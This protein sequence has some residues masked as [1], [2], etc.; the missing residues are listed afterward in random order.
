MFTGPQIRKMLRLFGIRLVT[1]SPGGYECKATGTSKRTLLL[2]S[3]KGAVRVSGYAVVQHD[4]GTPSPFILSPVLEQPIKRLT[5]WLDQPVTEVGFSPEVNSIRVHDG[6]YMRLLEQIIDNLINNC[7]NPTK[8]IDEILGL[9]LK[10]NPVLPTELQ[11]LNIVDPGWRLTKKGRY[12]R[13]DI[14]TSKLTYQLVAKRKAI[15]IRGKALLVMDEFPTPFWR[16]LVR[17]YFVKLCGQTMHDYVERVTNPY[18]VPLDAVD[19]QIRNAYDRARGARKRKD[20]ALNYGETTLAS[21]PPCIHRALDE[22]LLDMLRFNL[23]V[24]VNHITKERNLPSGLI[25]GQIMT[26]VSRSPINAGRAH[27]IR[28]RVESELKKAGGNYEDPI[29]CGKRARGSRFGGIMCVYDSPE[30][31]LHQRKGGDSLRPDTATIPLVWLFTDPAKR[32]ALDEEATFGDPDQSDSS[33]PGSGSTDSSPPGS[34][35][36]GSS[37]TGSSPT[38]SSP[39]GSS[40]T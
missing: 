33:P 16:Y 31:C 27:D 34:G 12:V 39:T 1:R 11:I 35:S 28:I 14:F 13:D 20:V 24:I 30:Q 38:G 37:S 2:V 3:A 17:L 23:A 19:V 32:S 8:F 26:H 40:P 4:E 21:A 25:L 22:P 6:V 15:L 36:T 18:F 29:C 10:G 9:Y 7:R 5:T